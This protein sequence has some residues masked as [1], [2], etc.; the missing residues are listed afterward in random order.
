MFPENLTFTQLIN[1]FLSCYVLKRKVNIPTYRSQYLGF[2][3]INMIAVPH[4]LFEI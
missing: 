3:L 1:N 2:I 4:T